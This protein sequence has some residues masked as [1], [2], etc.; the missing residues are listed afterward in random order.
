MT[1][2]LKQPVCEVGEPVHEE[3]RGGNG[4]DG[5]EQRHDGDEAG[6]DER[7]HG[8]GAEAAE[9][10]FGE[11][12]G[13]FGGTV[14]EEV[15][16]AGAAGVITISVLFYIVRPCVQSQRRRRSLLYA[17][18]YACTKQSVLTKRICSIRLHGA[19]RRR[20]LATITASER[21]REIATF[22]RLRL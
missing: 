12:A 5:H 20:G 14:A 1:V 3:E 10:R 7:Q 22:K 15:G 17:S 4:H 8:E 18:A 19:S 13:A 6:E 11:S 16:I 21:A 9:C 2:A